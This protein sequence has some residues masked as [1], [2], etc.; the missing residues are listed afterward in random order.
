MQNGN[1]EE[2]HSGTGIENKAEKAGFEL[3]G[4]FEEYQSTVCEI[5]GKFQ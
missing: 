3:G 5:R 2:G 4:K 1:H